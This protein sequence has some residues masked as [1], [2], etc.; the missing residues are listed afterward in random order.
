MTRFFGLIPRN[1]II[2]EKSYT[3]STGTGI[4]I[5]ANT[6]G[7]TIARSRNGTIYEDHIKSAIDNFT[8]AYNKAFK[9]Y[10]DL[11]EHSPWWD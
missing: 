6:K 8:D 3:D 2:I 11:R 10:G 7:W 5:Q 9:L 4:I 1:E